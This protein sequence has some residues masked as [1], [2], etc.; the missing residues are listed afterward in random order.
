[1]PDRTPLEVQRLRGTTDRLGAAGASKRAESAGPPPGDFRRSSAL[2]ARYLF[3]EQDR[4]ELLTWAAVLNRVQGT[5]NVA[6]GH[7]S[8]LVADSIF[9]GFSPALNRTRPIVLA[10]CYAGRM[11]SNPVARLI[12]TQAQQLANM[13]NLAVYGPDHLVQPSEVS[14][15]LEW[16]NANDIDSMGRTHSPV[17]SKH[18]DSPFGGWTWTY[19]QARGR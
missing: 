11:P 14:Q 2:G 1:M 6:M 8:G 16:L 12:G 18:L 9:R 4:D 10:S 3:N 19:P 15:V 17:F 7:N 5:I 13:A